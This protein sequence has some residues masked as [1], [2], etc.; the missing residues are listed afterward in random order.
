M[1]R[2]QVLA[3]LLLGSAAGRAQAQAVSPAPGTGAGQ[4][5][6]LLGMAA[7]LLISV[8]IAFAVLYALRARRR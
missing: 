1:S 2:L 8:I 5:D 7:L 3:A 6:G 4:S